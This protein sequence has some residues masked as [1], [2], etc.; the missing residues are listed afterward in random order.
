MNF[1]AGARYQRGRGLGSLFGGLLRGFMPVLNM[2]LSAGKRILQSDMAKN[3]GSTLLDSGS[4][5]V[6][7]MAAD[8]LEGKN[9]ATTA[10]DEL[11]NARKKIASTLRGSGYK[12]KKRSCETSVCKTNKRKRPNKNKKFNLLEDD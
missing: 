11:N 12:R 2:G 9:V 8:L 3:I 1:H 7:N 4:K 6:T 5:A 10:Q